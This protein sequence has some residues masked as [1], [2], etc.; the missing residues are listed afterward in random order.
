MRLAAR[1]EKFRIT[2]V[3]SGNIFH[4]GISTCVTIFEF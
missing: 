1:A 2:N 4:D 3:I